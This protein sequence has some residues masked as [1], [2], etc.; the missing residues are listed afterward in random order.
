MYLVYTNSVDCSEAAA[1]INRYYIRSRSVQFADAKLL[2]L[3]TTSFVD[4]DTVA[5][6]ELGPFAKILPG[7]RAGVLTTD[8][9]T[10]RWDVPRE[11]AA[12]DWAVSMPP[13]TLPADIPDLPAGYTEVEQPEWPII[14]EI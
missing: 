2:D 1:R 9:G 12:G 11:T 8:G 5:D 4:V 3:P 6:N 10:E 7:R 14:P 13:D